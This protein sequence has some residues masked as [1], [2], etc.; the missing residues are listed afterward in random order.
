MGAVFVVIIIVSGSIF[1]F[2]HFPSLY[3]LKRSQG[4]GVYFHVITLG[5]LFSAISFILLIIVDY[6]PSFPFILKEQNSLVDELNRLLLFSKPELEMAIVA[7]VTLVITVITGCFSKVVYFFSVGM[8]QKTIIK[9]IK[10]DPLETLLL[11]GALTQFPI[12]LN[13]KSRKAY[14]GIYFSEPSMEN[15]SKF[16]EIL[17]LLSGY[18]NEK[19]LE[20][21][22]VTN[23]HNHYENIGLNDGSHEYLTHDSFRVII[24]K[25][26]LDSVSF[27]DPE[28]Y[29]VFQ[30]QN[31]K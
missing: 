2:L 12:L 6:Y 28:T 5:C 11:E 25:S 18:R 19:T 3:K 7:M 22:I 16:I 31:R 1:S 15:D 14:V 29:K 8:R 20:L 30:K 24:F 27:F 4:W 13:L 23:Y 17:P 9:L 21:K 10:N 26:E